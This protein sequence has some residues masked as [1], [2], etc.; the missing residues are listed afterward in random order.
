MMSPVRF[1]RAS[2]ALL[3]TVALGVASSAQAC[4]CIPPDNVEAAARA[5]L[6]KADLVAELEV[7]RAPAPPW[8]WCRTSE[9]AWPWF[10]P[11]RTVEQDRAAR[12]LRVIKGHVS[13]P[14]RVRD[15]PVENH[16]GLCLK[17]RDTCEVFLN[18]GRTGPLLLRRVAPG[19]YE[20]MDICTQGAFAIWYER[21]RGRAVR[22]RRS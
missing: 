18:A 8:F 21:H 1:V 4:S 6:A 16:G 14:I 12:V 7:G 17:E 5:A 2:A 20:P 15:D 13:G 22:P 19:V 9:R 11:G 10:R 3:A